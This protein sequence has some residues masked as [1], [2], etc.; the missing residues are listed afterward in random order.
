M[1]SLRKLLQPDPENPAPRGTEN[2]SLRSFLS[3]RLSSILD[4]GVFHLQNA[5]ST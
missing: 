5:I 1:I 2:T 4:H 3:T